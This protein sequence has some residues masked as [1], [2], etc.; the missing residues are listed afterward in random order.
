MSDGSVRGANLIFKAMT[1]LD[2]VADARAPLRLSDLVQATGMP[3][4]T[5][6]RIAEALTAGR[7]IR[8]HEGDR[9]YR[10]GPRLLELARNAW[11]S[12]DLP[13]AADP[14]LS[15]LHDRLGETVALGLIIDGTVVLVDKRE[16]RHNLRTALAIGDR[17]Q[18]H[19]TAF[20]KAYLSAL[21]PVDQARI[22]SDLPLPACT[23]NSIVDARTL[24]AHLDMMATRGFAVEDEEVTL[25]VRSIASA[26]LDQRGRPMGVIG[27]TAPASSIGLDEFL[28]LGPEIVESARQISWT[29][30][31]NPPERWADHMPFQASS[32]KVSVAVPATAFMGASP[33][34]CDRRRR[35]LWVDVK[36]PGLHV[37]DPDAG[38]DEVIELP[39]L[40]GSVVLGE[41][42]TFVS[43]RS[44]LARVGTRG[45]EGPAVLDLLRDRPH[46]RYNTARADNLGRL[47]IATMDV[48]ISRA[49]GGLF[50]VDPDLSTHCVVDG[51]AV[52]IGIAW[53]PDYRTLYFCDAP[54]REVYQMDVNPESGRAENRRVFA[55]VP[56]GSGR[57]TGLAVDRDGFVWNVRTEGWCL[58]R[59]A[60]DG[61]IDRV[62]T[63]PVPKPI[64]CCFG[65]ENLQTL[66]VT[67]ARLGVPTRR[68]PEAPWSGS[69]LAVACAVPGMLQ[70]RLWLSSWVA[71]TP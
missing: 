28:D 20:G 58:V 18:L 11:E 39:E 44:G 32:D 46:Q 19:A 62:V 22:V 57:P 34:W 9:T 56:E 68:L 14:E 42:D 48:T 45:R 41:Q 40:A 17:M 1:V 30:G 23:P 50:R 71:R 36:R 47:W 12:L 70:P 63:L 5:V 25:G 60:P 54:R 8:R 51:L 53:S 49:S 59:Y 29:L 31:F 64:D 69:V 4:G 55:R 38:S 33:V 13:G 21:D 65:G 27:V 10:L 66:F 43:F 15:R 26:I 37:S 35:L 3:V 16:G 67:T 52:P 24:K 7:L 6:H 61:A 2:A